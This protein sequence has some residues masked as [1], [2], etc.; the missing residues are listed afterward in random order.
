MGFGKMIVQIFFRMPVLVK[1]EAAR[2]FI[3][4]MKMVV[5]TARFLARRPDQQ[6]ERI[7]K[8]LLLAGFACK[9]ATSDTLSDMFRFPYPAMARI[10][11]SAAFW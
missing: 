2:V 6:Q 3:A 8:L 9:Y 11:Y 10:I 4:A 5:D 7:H 1:H